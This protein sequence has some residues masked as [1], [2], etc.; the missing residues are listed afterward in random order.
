[1]IRKALGVALLA[2]SSTSLAQ[3]DFA[4]NLGIP[5]GIRI[6][7]STYTEVKMDLDVRTRFIAANGAL[8]SG[9]LWAPATGTCFFTASGGVGCNLQADQDSITVSLESNLS[10]TITAKNANGAIYASRP[11]SVTGVE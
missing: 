2:A 5:G 3:A 9:L 11:I 1:M 4:I 8:V 10:G 7:D 6:G